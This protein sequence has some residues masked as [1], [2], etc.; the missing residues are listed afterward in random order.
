MPNGYYIL[1]MI[2]SNGTTHVPFIVIH[3]IAQRI[4][5][6]LDVLLMID[7][8]LDDLL[9]RN[10]DPAERIVDIIPVHLRSE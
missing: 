8:K 9:Q 5:S 1:E 3:Y 4:P 10:I 7:D 6:S 2:T